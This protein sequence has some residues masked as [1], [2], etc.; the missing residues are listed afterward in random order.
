VVAVAIGFVV[1]LRPDLFWG[2][3]GFFDRSDQSSDFTSGRLDIWEHVFSLWGGHPV[4]GIGYHTVELVPG[5]GD[6]NAHNLFLLV[7]AELGLVGIVI[8]G[9]LIVR[10]ILVGFRSTSPVDRMLIGG[11]V[12]VL[13]IE[14]TEAS[15][16]GFGGPTAMISWIALLAFGATGRS[17]SS[18]RVDPIQAGSAALDGSGLDKR[19]L[20]SSRADSISVCIAT[21]NGS[22]F[23][24]EQL[25]SILDQLGPDDEVMV[26]DDGS[27]DD[28]VTV[29]RRLS[30]E[31][32]RVHVNERNTGHVTAFEAAIQEA[33]GQLIFLADQDD[34]WLPGRVRLLSDGL[35]N[36]TYVA[37]NWSILGEQSG[38]HGRPLLASKETSTPWRNIGRLYLGSI[39]YFGCAMAFR[40]EAL[41]L[42]L[43]FPP[44][45]EAHDHWIALA[46][47]MDGGIEHLPQATVARRL[48]ENNL[49]AG[50]RSMGMVLRTRLKLTFLLATILVRQG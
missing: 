8:F 30:D 19:A 29:L 7:L 15:M 25:R 48:H 9:A 17:G 47:N 35:K 5:L 6:L 32:V 31:R 40:R 13:V 18:G 50:R 34:V 46:G 43:P 39:P 2:D 49:T 27:Q 36:R 26:I 3:G 23:V 21:Y 11:V 12:T 33:R 45:V 24:E 10:I 1:A 28:T 4:A 16:F 42:L 44:M 20:Q 37:S 14:L 22:R 38:M 41:S